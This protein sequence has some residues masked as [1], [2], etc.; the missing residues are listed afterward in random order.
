MENPDSKE[1]WRKKRDRLITE[2]IDVTTWMTN[3]IEQYAPGG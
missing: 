3:F 2:K 1:D